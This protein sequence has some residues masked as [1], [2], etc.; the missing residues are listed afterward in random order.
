MAKGLDNDEE[1]IPR[2]NLIRFR[3]EHGWS[4]AEASMRLGGS[5]SASYLSKI[6]TGERKLPG[7][8]ILNQLAEAYGHDV[9]D[10]LNPNPPPA[11]P[12]LMPV[13]GPLQVSASADDAALIADELAEFKRTYEAMDQELRIKL[14]KRRQAKKK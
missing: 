12:G 8:L 4:H 6:E 14:R 5:I 13:L 10:L 2:G 9:K 3:E 11:D 1:A 7:F